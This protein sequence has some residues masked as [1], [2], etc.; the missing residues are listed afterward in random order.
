MKSSRRK[1]AQSTGIGVGPRGLRRIL[2]LAVG[3]MIGTVLAVVYA[4]G[5]WKKGIE[6]PPVE[7]PKKEQKEEA[8]KETP[9]MK[10]AATSPY[11][12]TQP[13]VK[14]V[15]SQACIACHE[16]E[17][18]T[19]Q[20]TGMAQSMA[21]IDL[22]RE[23]PDGGFDHRPSK[24]RY[25]VVRKDGQMW[26]RELLLTGGKEE[27]LLQE[28]PVKY[29][30]GSGRHS[31]TYVVEDD[32]F[33]ME[34][35]ITWYASRKAWGMS[36]GYDRPHHFSFERE[37]GEN[38][39][40]CHAGQVKPE[41]KSLHRMH[42]TEAAIGCEQC[43]GPGELHVQLQEAAKKVPQKTSADGDDTIVN[44]TRLTR[45]LSEAVCQ[46]CHLRASAAVFSQRK[47]PFD[48]RP[49]LPLG[50]FVQHFVLETPNP[51]MSVVGHVEQMHQSKCYQQTK[52]F[53][54]LTCHAPHGEPPKG[55]ALTQHYNQVCAKCHQPEACHVSPERR[56]K[57]N[58]GNDCI[59]CHMPQT[60]TDIP[61]LA[62]THHRV[63]IHDAKLGAKDTSLAPASDT[64]RPVLDLSSLGEKER[65]RALGLAYLEIALKEEN[66]SHRLRY[67]REG[68]ALL[69]AVRSAGGLD[70]PVDAGL[71][72]LRSEQGMP[73]SQRYVQ[74]AL[75][76]P[77]LTGFDLCTSLFFHAESQFQQRHYGEAI[78]TL[79]QLNKLR[80]HSVQW[81]LIAQCQQELGNQ[82]KA[83]EA[84]IQAVHIN[85]RLTK[86]H[87][88]L[89]EIYRQRGNEVR[90]KYHEARAGG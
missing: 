75:A 59:A 14:Y 20:H 72:R 34:S 67:Q 80:R 30:T 32:G 48:F 17:H 55:E 58:P 9:S 85:P 70:G 78:R 74:S 56:Q 29:V 5:L 10:L 76:D 23:P 31:L 50:E 62:F 51:L 40:V 41:G 33:L 87:R 24:S 45:E 79:E 6:K 88:Q 2:L 12:N 46:Q 53:S 84:L 4:P 7:S 66:R 54:C 28:Y 44:P 13:G 43:H 71:A 60:P 49:G 18:A 57:E 35:P 86:I 37:I 90:A 69:S 21:A 8:A 77:Q 61:H 73:D 25:E 38:C 16:Q 68:F 11:K 52:S 81:L 3:V 64:L 26:H 27:L 1:P 65:N 89:A 36:P 22:T 15:G 63:G 39:L 47:T 83:E 19:Y 42:I 82:A